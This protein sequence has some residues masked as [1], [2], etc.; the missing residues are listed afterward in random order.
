MPWIELIEFYWFSMGIAVFY[1]VA[2]IWDIEMR[3]SGLDLELLT[4][5]IYA[6]HPRVYDVIYVCCHPRRDGSQQSMAIKMYSKYTT[7]KASDK[8]WSQVTKARID[9][10]GK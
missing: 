7:Y 6:V 5:H 10:V 4:Y 9:K 3:M 1:L 8:I 2:E